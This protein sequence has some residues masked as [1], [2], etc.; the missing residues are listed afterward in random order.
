MDMINNENYVI[1]IGE[2]WVRAGGRTM[3]SDEQKRAS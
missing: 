1:L 3:P 2:E